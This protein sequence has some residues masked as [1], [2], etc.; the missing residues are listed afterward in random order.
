MNWE[1]AI[2]K[3]NGT[4][5]GRAV[6]THPGS[7]GRTNAD[8]VAA[9]IN[10]PRDMPSPPWSL[11]GLN[12][13]S[14]HP[15]SVVR[16]RVPSSRTCGWCSKG[17][18]AQQQDPTFDHNRSMTV[19]PTGERVDEPRINL[20]LLAAVLLV[21]G[22][23]IRAA[24]LPTPGFRDDLD[25][26]VL[27]VHGIATTGLPNAYDQNLAFPPV[28]AY[29]FGLLGSI[30]PAFRSVTTAADPAIRAIMKAP[31]SLADL[32]LGLVV[33]W[34]LRAT[35]RWALLG[36][37]AILLHPAVVDVSAWWGQFE[38]I[39]V[40][41]GVVAY[42]LAVRGH[43]L[44]AAA[45]LAVALMT[46]PQALPL[47]VPFAAWF[48]AHDGWRGAVRAALVGIAVI[49]VLWLPFLA[50]GGI[51]GYARTLGSYQ[52]DTFA[53]LSLRA[54]N[55]WW[56]VQELLAGGQFVSDQSSIA[57]PLTLRNVGFGLAL[58][59]ELAVFALVYRARSPRALAYGLAAAVLV[60]FCLL[61]TMHE[62]YAF[63]AL[64]FL[65]LAF[66]DRRAAWLALGFGVV[67]T[68]NLLA[69]IPPTPEIGRLL[70][71]TG[72]L[73]VAGSIAMLAILGATL[74]LLR[75]EVAASAGARSAGEDPPQPAR[76]RDPV[77]VQVVR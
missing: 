60:A 45:L 40:L 23:A 18:A 32:G 15:N 10:G 71:V 42:V 7:L 62:R 64:A 52:G 36:G 20:G 61:T 47:L 2:A 76:E 41:G 43:S 3:T 77:P 11:D 21:A 67:F 48:L 73:G 31:A 55:L 22:A 12:R 54:W 26:F 14:R 8:V 63:G 56:L 75:A 6:A 69:A 66:P 50:A 53:I 39:Y 25:Q 16:R 38:S 5:M 70:P 68:L 74:V 46:K 13:P 35:P 44:W 28:M 57:G 33:M 49:A 4:D 59:G 72:P 29:I 24:I 17:T 27:W 37:A 9:I 34:H 1:L 65:V 30:E 58:A 51:Q 19:I